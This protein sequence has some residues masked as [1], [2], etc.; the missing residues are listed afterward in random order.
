MWVSILRPVGGEGWISVRCFTSSCELLFV[1]TSK[2][3]SNPCSPREHSDAEP[4][5][6]NGFRPAL[7][8]GARGRRQGREVTA[9]Q[10]LEEMPSGVSPPS[11]PGAQR[12]HSG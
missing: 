1:S 8:A 11:L 10:G 9:G 12:P 7:K 2:T 6:A 3:R 5:A 4:Q